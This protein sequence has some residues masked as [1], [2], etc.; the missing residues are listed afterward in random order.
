MENRETG[1][2]GGYGGVVLN[3]AM[4]GINPFAVEAA[5]T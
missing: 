3:K 5:I 4:G 2:I 1:G